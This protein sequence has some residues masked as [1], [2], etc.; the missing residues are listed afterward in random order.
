[1]R[2]RDKAT[3]S[4]LDQKRVLASPIRQELIDALSRTGP[5]SLTELGAL[6]G[7]PADGL[8]YHLRLLRRVGLVAAAGS[9]VRNGRREDLFRSGAAQYE[10]KY[11]DPS[12]RHARALNAIIASMM[13]LGIRD[14]RRALTS[15][16]C[17]L[18]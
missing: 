7:R 11:G 6:L 17:T 18:A 5:S 4:R 14:F 13:R 16:T 8:Y 3:I 2:V 1:M 10:L 15:G 9:R 12:P